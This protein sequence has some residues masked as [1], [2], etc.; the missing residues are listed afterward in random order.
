MAG[1]SLT[2]VGRAAPRSFGIGL[3]CVT[4]AG[5]AC[6]SSVAPTSAA[7]VLAGDDEATT[8]ATRSAAYDEVP[9]APVTTSDLVANGRHWRIV[10]PNGPVHV[11]IPP[12]YRRRRADTVVYV[13][14]FYTSV[15]RA[16]KEHFLASQFASSAINAVFI[17]CAAPAGP[18]E[19][20]AWRSLAS[21]LDAVT[22]GIARP[23][24]RRRIVAVGHSGAHRTLREWLDEPQLDTIVLV[25]AAYGEI[26]SFRAWVLARPRRRLINIGDGTKKAGDQLHASLPGSVMLDGFPDVEDEIPPA[27]AKARILYIRSSLG[28]FPLV[29]GGVALPMILRTLRSR[30][31][32]DVPL[33]DLVE[34][35]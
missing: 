23:L 21:L 29:T 13:H 34:S 8:I 11:W 4:L 30:L 15:D 5:A 1:R 14:G 12:G 6:S 31:L 2:V 22:R 20:V 18:G 10:T 24:P 7:L 16:W 3:A 33:A 35:R 32:L 19:R 17:A 26:E 27:A 9:P 28:H 25:D